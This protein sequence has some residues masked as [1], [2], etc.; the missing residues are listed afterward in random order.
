MSELKN[1]WGKRI[2]PFVEIVRIIRIM[3]MW[4]RLYSFFL[5]YF[6]YFL[7]LTVTKR[8]VLLFHFSSFPLF[9]L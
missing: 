8:A 1:Y 2:N 6:V 9:K 5:N 7:V 3:L 4:F